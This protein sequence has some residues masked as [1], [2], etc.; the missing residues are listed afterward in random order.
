M[1]IKTKET[2]TFRPTITEAQLGKI[3]TRW[4]DDVH[5][6]VS[7]VGDSREQFLMVL[8]GTTSRTLAT[9]RARELVKTLER[10]GSA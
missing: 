1:K 10:G 7:E 2:K 6:E 8:L 5:V 3:L 9:R 4:P